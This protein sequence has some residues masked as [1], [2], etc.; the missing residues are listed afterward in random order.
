V[1]A[2]FRFGRTNTID[3]SVE[4]TQLL[5]ILGTS[6]LDRG[7]PRRHEGKA[8]SKKQSDILERL[9]PR[10][11]AFLPHASRGDT[12]AAQRDDHRAFPVPRAP[13]ILPCYSDKAEVA[14]RASVE[15]DRDRCAR[16]AP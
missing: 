1:L 12:K 9:R 10:A 3:D 14:T 6:V 8:M 7:R 4:M 15:S 5:C 2:D 16:A 13:T 11:R